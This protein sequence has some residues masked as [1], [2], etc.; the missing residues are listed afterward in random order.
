MPFV[1]LSR[2]AHRRVDQAGVKTRL[3]LLSDLSLELTR[4]PHLRLLKHLRRRRDFARQRWPLGQHKIAVCRVAAT[5][6]ARISRVPAADGCALWSR[7]WTRYLPLPS[8]LRRNIFPPVASA[9]WSTFGR[10][11]ALVTRGP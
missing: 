3:G 4:H 2:F 5:A 1:D 6:A 7:P 10:G 11:S 8:P 9:L